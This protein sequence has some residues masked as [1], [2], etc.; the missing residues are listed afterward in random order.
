[1]IELK[2]ISR[3]FEGEAG[4][5][6]EALRDVTLRISGGEFVC[7]TGPSG[8]GKSTLMNILGCLD[9]PSSGSYRLAGRA[10]QSMGADGHALLRRRIFGF[11]FQ[12]YNLV[13]SATAQENVEL[14]GSY[15]GLS[16]RAR[17][18]RAKALL[19]QLDL[20][21]RAGHLPSELSGGEQQ[22][23]A[24]ARALMNGGHVIL[25]DEPTGALDR[26]S[27]EEVLKAL[28][29]LAAT[30]HTVVMISHNP[31]VAARANRHIELLDG[32]VI[33]DTDS[34]PSRGRRPEEVIP[35]T[36]KGQALLSRAAAPVR[37]SWSALRINLTHGARLRTALLIGVILTA[38]CSGTVVLSIGEGTYN[39]TI[40]TANHMGLDTIRVA[41]K[42]WKPTLAG[43]P[44][45]SSSGPRD[46]LP[47]TQ[48]DA[49]AIRD[50]ISNVRAVSPY[51]LVMPLM[52]RRSE[53]ARP[54]Q[55][56]GF[57]D[58]GTKLGRG[59]LGYRL[60]AGEYITREDDDN[61]A[62][63][64]VLES[65]IRNRLFPPETDPL[66]Q[67][68]FIEDIAFRVKGI[69]QPRLLPGKMFVAGVKA[70]IPFKTA[71]A[72]LT[73]RNEIDEIYVFVE[74]PA[75]LF[76]T[77]S[78]IRDIGIRRRGGDTLHIGHTGGVVQEAKKVRAQLW[79]VLGTIAGCVLLAGNFSVMNIMLL[80]VRARHREIGIRMAVGAR[81]SDILRQFLG[82]AIVISVVGAVIGVLCAV[83]GIW[84]LQ[85]LD[86]AI[87]ASLLFFALPIIC[88]L[89]FGAL[90]GIMPA[91]RAA[92]L[93]PVAALASD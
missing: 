93:D 90:F 85:R 75:R 22:R 71:T 63:V 20:V 37:E 1:M 24:I 4:V 27:G 57:V 76:E 35:T 70:H 58:L 61:L 6:V 7:I 23:V 17:Q 50:Q 74:D 34:G 69:Y 9:R 51:I 53:V 40:R 31:E 39:E 28:E 81:R 91:H 45:A 65:N 56:L 55:V 13:E 8:A 67:E 14:P 59:P 87:E 41:P 83:V 3:F 38:V 64:A 26:K 46:F 15:A 62:R 5:R 36:S 73:S 79:L 72:L 92:Q 86:V 42:E 19:A 66:G 88:A 12:S 44:D 29:G 32:R 80:S 48:A 43:E 33:G 47:L 11:V 2:G 68:I 54:L 21:D 89:G 49:R 25:A 82:E 52:A 16:R 30:G 84:A 77:V 18:K 78:A 10:V 60:E